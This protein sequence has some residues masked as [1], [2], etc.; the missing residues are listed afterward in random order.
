MYSIDLFHTIKNYKFKKKNPFINDDSTYH[1]KSN[2]QKNNRKNLGM[3]Y[4]SS[5]YR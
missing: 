2:K 5:V 4:Y 1:K 3:T